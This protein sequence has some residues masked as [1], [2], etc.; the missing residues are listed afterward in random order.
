MTIYRVRCRPAATVN[1]AVTVWDITANPQQISDPLVV[2]SPTLIELKPDYPNSDP[3]MQG[4]IIR[5]N[6]D[7]PKNITVVGDG[8]DDVKVYDAC[9]T[10]EDIKLRLT[11]WHQ[12][13][14]YATD[15]GKPIIR[16][17]PLTMLQFERIAAAI[18]ALAAAAAIA[19]IG[20]YYFEWW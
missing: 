16:N 3:S 14:G 11:V 17:R 18:L 2:T 19:A 7:N 15:S 4:F 9:V 1:Y 5:V 10:S 13:N 20:H 6:P 8:T 12:V